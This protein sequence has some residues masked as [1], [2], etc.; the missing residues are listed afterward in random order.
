MIERKFV[1]QKFK[2]F[3]IKQYIKSQLNKVGLSDVKVQRTSLGEKIIISANRPGLVVGRGGGVIQKLTRDMKDVFKLENP[4]I[5]IE[6][7]KD[8]NFDADVIAE[9]IVTQLERF[10]SQRFKGIGHK[11]MT[12]VMD[13]GALGIEIL[14]SGKV[15]SSRAKSWRF[16]M[17]YMKKCGDVAITGVNSSITYAN[18]KTGIIGIQVKIMPPTTIL[19]DDIKILDKSLMVQ[20]VKTEQPKKEENKVVTKKRTTKKEGT[21]NTEEKKPREKKATTRKTSPKK[22]TNKTEE[23]KS[24]K[25]KENIVEDER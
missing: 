5:E 1:A 18:L 16:A 7:I 8:V 2:E 6:E 20:E 10:G 3:H 4:Q 13:A 17:G 22:A 9:Y 23:E 14:I 11:V 25:P 19:P 24:S 12:R 21:N 15:P